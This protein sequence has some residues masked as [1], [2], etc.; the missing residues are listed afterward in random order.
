M[1]SSQK[2]VAQLSV[3]CASRTSSACSLGPASFR[4]SSTSSR[5]LSYWVAGM[6]ALK[7]ARYRSSVLPRSGM[8]CCGSSCG[9]RRQA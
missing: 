4:K 9:E 3:F 8:G 6:T 5:V 2:L 7:P 1:S